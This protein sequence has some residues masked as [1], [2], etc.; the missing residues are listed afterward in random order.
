[1]IQTEYFYRKISSDNFIK[2]SSPQNL[3][4][5]RPQNF[6]NPQN[7]YY[8][9]SKKTWTQSCEEEGLFVEFAQEPVKPETKLFKRSEN[10][11]K[12]YEGYLCNSDLED[13][14]QSQMEKYLADRKEQQKFK[15]F[16]RNFKDSYG[17]E[18]DYA[19]AFI[20]SDFQ[21]LTLKIV[22]NKFI[23]PLPQTTPFTEEKTLFFDMKNG[24][25]NISFDFKQLPMDVIEAGYQKL[26]DLAQIFTGVSFDSMRNL[27][28]IDSKK[29]I[30]K[31]KQITMIPFAP[32]LYNII[33]SPVIE[34]R[35]LLFFY[36][37]TD[38][39]VFKHFLKRAKIKNTKTVRKCYME[40]PEVLLT[41]LRLKDA[42][43]TD[44]NLYNKVLTNK[45]NYWLID[46]VDAKALAFFCRWSIKKRGQ[47]NTMN[48]ILKSDGSW[49][50]KRDG[51][52]MFIKY[53]KH[54]PAEL[55]KDILINGF[56][57]YNHDAL[58]NLSKQFENK[59]ITF[60]YTAEEKKLEDD[61]QDYKFRLPKNSYKLIEIGSELH[62]CVASYAD[63]VKEKD[64]TIIFVTKDNKYKFC[65]EVRG[66]EINQ[67]YADYNEKPCKEEQIIL[68]QWHERHN[69]ILN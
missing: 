11:Y 61:I 8:S 32:E 14:D 54:I 60:K 42:G 66:H 27:Y 63:S 55:K 40:R 69:L 49:Y 10:L 17:I 58:A 48:T 15:F 31:M 34:K 47:K 30:K 36:K 18:R 6:Y 20:T 9:K 23:R 35:H 26:L 12:D 37:R 39:K 16:T 25:V 24:S 44:M 4:I 45:E 3:I 28:F 51:L 41:Y 21:N 64:C 50:Y 1:M 7:L 59:N 65:I 38:S 29:A 13:L 53:F 2:F 46:N 67:E 22:F 52:N 56:T 5:T 19:A 68:D 62:N 43:F 33:T 57:N